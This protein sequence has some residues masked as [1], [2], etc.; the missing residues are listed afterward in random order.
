[1]DQK[2][3]KSKGWYLGL[4]YMEDM[5]L[6][7]HE[8]KPVPDEM[9][10]TAH[11]YSEGNLFASSEWRTVIAGWFESL[12]ENGRL[13]L[14][15]P[16]CRYVDVPQG[17]SR[18]TRED[19]LMAFDGL[20]GWACIE[21]DMIDGH[22]FAVFEKVGGEAKEYRP[23]RKKPK[24]CLVIRTGAFGDALMASSVFPGLVEQGYAIDYYSHQIGGEVL[25]HDP[26][27]DRVFTTKPNQTPDGELP[28]FW[29]ALS[30]RY[31]KTVNLTY[32]VE[33]PLLSQPWR[34]EF[35]WPWD[36][37]DRMC[38]GSYLKSQHDCAGV[39]GPYRVKF[40]PT[41]E[42]REWADKTA[43][44]VGPFVLWCLR[45]SAGHK[46]YPW[47]PQ[48]ICQLLV[49]RPELTIVLSGDEGSKGL[50]TQ[51]L[52][53]ASEYLGDVSRFRSLVGTGSIRRPMELAKR[54]QVVVGPETGVLNAVGM[55]PV[56]KVCMLSHSSPSNLTDDWVNAYALES[57]GCPL[58]KGPCHQLH[59]GHDYCPQ[60]K[61]TGAAV[62][63]SSLVPK[64]LV[65]TILKALEPKR[66]SVAA[67]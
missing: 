37:R 27:V 22:H 46:W 48:A 11:I 35:F 54:A 47:T 2:V 59:Y 31:D 13:I 15:L 65:D 58:N 57:K 17:N 26:H 10:N 64:E 6:T 29:T 50:E 30:G 42:E 49:K 60:D 32:S 14:F 12:K 1:M 23:W 39:P 19:I 41:D 66:L 34:S 5:G 16:D 33:G 38:S 40:Y 20:K 21:D 44:E 18:A 28:Q 61:Q 56:A 43:N 53:A 52:E 62:C 25:R 55:E 63:S 67:E 45:G 3:E 7:A 4:Q 9:R 36:Q 24:H 8:P 51:I